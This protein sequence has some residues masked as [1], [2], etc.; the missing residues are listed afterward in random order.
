MWQ[1]INNYIGIL[2]MGIGAIVFGKIVLEKRVKIS[3]LK[4]IIILLV[5]TLIFTIGYTYLDGTIKTLSLYIVYLYLFKIVYELSYYKAIF[6]TFIYTILVMISDIL[7]LLAITNI[8]G[9]DKIICYDK[10]AGS[11]LSNAIVCIIFIAI[12]L[13]LKKNLRKIINTEVSNN[14]KIIILSIITLIPILLFFYSLIREFKFS[15]DVIEYLVAIIVLL[16]ILFSLIKQTIENNKLINEYDELL[17]FMSTYELEIEKQRIL[18]HETKNEFLTIKAKICDKQKEQEIINYID[19]IVEDKIIVKQEEYAKFGYL[20]PN[21]IKGLCYFKTQ[22][23]EEKGITVALNISKRI[24]DCN[25]HNLT[26]KQQR[27]FGRILGVLLDNAIEASAESNQKKLGIE[28]YTNKDKEF[29]MIISNSF[30]N[31]IEKDK[32][33]QERFSTKGKNRGHGLLLVNHIIGANEIFE[34]KT[35]NTNDIYVQT[36]T[37]KNSKKK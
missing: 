2:I 24:K 4:L 7:E 23:A 31:K 13:I 16:T 18:R 37:I 30:N 36:I 21:G 6:L 14:T 12:T 19:E 3:K 27:E 25:I 28:V 15:N 35:E 33:G 20:P 26:T 5:A 17:E 9:M 8:A 32:I 29:K 10:F 11:I 34:L 1:I 22:E